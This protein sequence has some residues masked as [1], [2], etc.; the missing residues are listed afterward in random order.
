MFA[1]AVGGAAPFWQVALSIVLMVLTLLG[2][3]VGRR[4]H[5]SGG[6]SDDGEAADRDRVAAL[7]S[8]G[9]T[10]WPAPASVRERRS[11]KSH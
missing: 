7:A 11:Q 6:D 10:A 2:R 5:L 8:P 3:G 4:A 1:R 9:V